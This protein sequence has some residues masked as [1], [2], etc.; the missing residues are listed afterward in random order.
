MDT[1]Q[2]QLDYP[3]PDDDFGQHYQHE[4]DQYLEADPDYGFEEPLTH[5]VTMDM[6]LEAAIGLNQ[7]T[8]S[9]PGVAVSGITSGLFNLRRR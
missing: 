2:E 4:L 6:A 5:R 1:N 3:L 8:L 9:L 7:P